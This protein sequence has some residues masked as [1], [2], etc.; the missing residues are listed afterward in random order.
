MSIKLRPT[1]LTDIDH[2]MGWINDPDVVAS[3]A[4]IQKSI[5]RKDETKW[6]QQSLSNPNMRL[7]SIYDRKLYVGQAS[8]PQIYW[9]GRNARFSVMITKAFQG[10]GLGE[11][12]AAL[13][14]NE[15]FKKLKLHK[16]WCLVLENNP[17][18]VHL[19]CN[20]L[21][22]KEEGRL[23]DDYFLNGRYHTMLRLYMT[24]KMWL[25]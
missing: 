23:I 14:F 1:Q 5:S 19:Y 20:K 7:Y 12:A 4:N 21:K 3:I 18:T 25:R 17:K 16:L 10:Q 9:P 8:L 6:L 24:E 11:Q 15:A 2:I 13:L 22:M